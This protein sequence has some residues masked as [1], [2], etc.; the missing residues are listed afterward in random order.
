MS[1]FVFA[2]GA[3]VVVGRGL[4]VAAA[5]A[6]RERD[7]GAEH[8]DE[9][10]DDGEQRPAARASTTRARTGGGVGLHRRL[11]VGDRPW[12]ARAPNRPRIIC[13]HGAEEDGRAIHEAG[14]GDRPRAAHRVLRR[15]ATGGDG[16]DRAAH[17]VKV[18]GEVR[19]VRI[20]PR[21]GAPALEVTVSDGRGSIVGVFL[22][23]RKIAG[24]SPGRKVAFEGVSRA[25]RQA[26][27]AVQPD[28]R[29]AELE[30]ARRRRR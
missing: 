16:L 29:A 3:F 19:S 12:L 14:R 11:R 1:T 4:V 30:Q 8:D 24:L 23:R 9:D 5:G 18:G 26:L 27:P 25:R 22:G 6:A 17:R 28:L 2:A 13:P 20:V 15:P 10:R 21:A 7:P